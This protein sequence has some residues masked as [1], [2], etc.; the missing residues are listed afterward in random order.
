VDKTQL[1]IALACASVGGQADLARALGITPAAVNQWCK[2]AREVPAERCPAIEGLTR[3]AAFEK[4]DPSLIVTCEALRPD[5]NW[6][7]LRR[8]RDVPAEAKAG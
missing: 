1:A 4:G 3:R 5:V 8:E 7:V 6:G 2:G